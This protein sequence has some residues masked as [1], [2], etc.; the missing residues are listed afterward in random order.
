VAW[1]LIAGTLFAVPLAAWAED[2]AADAANP[3]DAPKESARDFPNRFTF[4]LNGPHT[5]AGDADYELTLGGDREDDFWRIDASFHLTPRHA[6]VFSYYDVMRTGHRKLGRDV[7]IEDKTFVANAT[8]D[9]EPDIALY[10]L[11]YF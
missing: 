6:F 11:Y 3:S 5:V 10:R 4:T 7:T 8:V 9:S 2:A 1:T